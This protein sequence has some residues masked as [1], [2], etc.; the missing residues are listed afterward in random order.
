MDPNANQR[1]QNEILERIARGVAGA[2]ELERLE[3][4]RAALEEWRAAG[5]F[6]P[7]V[8]AE[9]PELLETCSSCGASALQ[10]DPVDMSC[11]ELE[12]LEEPADSL[13]ELRELERAGDILE[14]FRALYISRDG[15]SAARTHRPDPADVNAATIVRSARPARTSPRDRA[16]A[17]HVLELAGLNAPFEDPETAR[18]FLELETGDAPGSRYGLHVSSWAPVAVAYA[19]ILAGENGDP[20]TVDALE[21]ASGPVVNDSPDPLEIITSYGAS[22]GFEELAAELRREHVL[23]PAADVLEEIAGE[24]EEESAELAATGRGYEARAFELEERRRALELAADV[25]RSAE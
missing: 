16:I 6:A 3:E 24:L 18:A 17:V 20:L 21:A 5:G 25:L 12:E 2:G 10:H 22:H 14:A 11:P 19:A 15:T 1:E 9:H 7:D 8:P 13:R 4:L 23:E